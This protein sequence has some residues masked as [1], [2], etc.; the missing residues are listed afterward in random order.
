ML[1]DD[2]QQ[3]PLDKIIRTDLT[4]NNAMT[5]NDKQQC[6]H[7]KT[8]SE[9]SSGG[10]CHNTPLLALSSCQLLLTQEPWPSA[11][12]SCV[13][14]SLPSSLVLGARRCGMPLPGS[15]RVNPRLSGSGMP[16]SAGHLGLRK[17]RGVIEHTICT[18]AMPVGRFLAGPIATN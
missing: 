13:K 7:C 9:N 12:S 6:I 17:Q 5:M 18:C 4:H 2:N 14:S 16:H 3:G 8:H 15:A 11:L 10:H 1:E